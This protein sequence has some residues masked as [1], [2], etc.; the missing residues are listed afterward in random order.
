MLQVAHATRMPP[1]AICLSSRTHARI[2]LP[3][4]AHEY[5][6]GRE[7]GSV[8]YRSERSRIPSVGVCGRVVGGRYG[9]VLRPLLF[10]LGLLFY[11]N[12][13]IHT[14]RFK[15]SVH[16][17]AGVSRTTSDLYVVHHVYLYCPMYWCMSRLESSRESPAQQVPCLRVP[18][19]STR[20]WEE[21]DALWWAPSSR[22]H[23][24]YQ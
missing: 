16:V 3:R 20:T 7:H 13:L 12:I 9:K 19:T 24:L 22:N 21:V 14:T 23:A 6:R 10:E 2:P 5:R 8:T 18:R 1:A 4:G 17:V 11:G 15:Q